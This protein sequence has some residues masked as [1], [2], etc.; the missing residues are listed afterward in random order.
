MIAGL[1]TALRRRVRRGGVLWKVLHGCNLVYRAGRHVASRTHRLVK[2]SY[3]NLTRNSIFWEASELGMCSLYPEEKLRIVL[4]RLAPRS[5]LDLGCGTGKA[6]DFFLKHGIDVA[7]V[8]GSD[9]AIRCARH[10]ERIL[11]RNLNEELKLGRRFDLVWSFEFVEHIHPNYV[12][13][14]LRS[15]ANHADKIVLSAA[16][17]GQGG[18]GHFNEQPPEYWVAQFQT[19]GFQLDEKLTEELRGCDEFFSENMLVFR[20]VI[21]DNSV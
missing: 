10:P 13:N 1:E 16:R 8:D 3:R 7:G 9:M 5:V 15:F 20:R 21:S 2:S 12:S 11:R 6:L 18:E 14:L 19:V 17:P 4:E